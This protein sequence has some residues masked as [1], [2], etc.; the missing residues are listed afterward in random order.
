MHCGR[1][2]RFRGSR[3]EDIMVGRFPSLTPLFILLVALG[4]QL[5]FEAFPSVA[6]SA[7]PS[8][9]SRHDGDRVK[10][11]ILAG[12]KSHGPTGNGLHEYL[13]SA[14]LLK[15]MLT[16][17]RTGTAVDVEIHDKG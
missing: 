6:R 8:L 10:I 4:Y 5:G 2:L 11:V 7:E 1:G 12:P 17:A 9:A 16:V 14:R 15:A 3:F 13:R